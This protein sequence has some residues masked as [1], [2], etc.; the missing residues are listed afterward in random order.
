MLSDTLT[1]LDGGKVSNF[2][3]ESGSSFPTAQIGELF[4]LTTTNTLYFYNGTTWKEVSSAGGTDV[5]K[6]NITGTITVNTGAMRWYPDRNITLSKVYFS[7]GTSPSGNV[8]I[9]VK[10][11]GT[12]I[13]S[14]TYPTCTSGNYLSSSVTVSTNL[15]ST[16]YITVD[17][18]AGTSGSDAVVFI[19]YN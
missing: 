14:G 12:S 11:N 1:F 7:L 5:T 18:T 6:Y 2:A 10:K 8:V 17:V 13:F 19:V 15:T 3:V 9:D 4:F 16:D